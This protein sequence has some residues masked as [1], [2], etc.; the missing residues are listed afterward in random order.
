MRMWLINPK[1]L[2]RLHLLGEHFEIHK[3]LGNLRNSG[4]WVRNLVLKG[5]LEPQNFKK[6]H[7]ILVK[8]MVKRG[9]KHNSPLLIDVSLPIG[10]VDIGKS[11]KDLIKRC[12]KCRRRFRRW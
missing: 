9:F 12:L 11:K 8:E 1:Y 6:R 7:D 2:C 10:Y 4:G 3:A 5:F